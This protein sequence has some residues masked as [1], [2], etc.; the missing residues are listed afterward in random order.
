[1]SGSREMTTAPSRSMSVASA[2]SGTPGSRRISW[3]LI[4]TATKTSPVSAADAPA[5]ATKRSV[6]SLAPDGFTGAEA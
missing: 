1:M 5:A 6:H 3:M 2:R 4:E